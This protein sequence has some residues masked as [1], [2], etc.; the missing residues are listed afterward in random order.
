MNVDRRFLLVRTQRLLQS[1]A[2]TNLSPT[3]NAGLWLGTDK[4]FSARRRESGIHNAVLALTGREVSCCGFS[5]I[6]SFIFMNL[7]ITEHLRYS[8]LLRLSFPTHCP[9]E[10]K[11]AVD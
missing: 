3:V 10:P 2:L 1:S 6:N 9:T 7:A 11:P 5:F 4:Q 8:T